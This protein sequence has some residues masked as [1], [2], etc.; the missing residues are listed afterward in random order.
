MSPLAIT[1]ARWVNSVQPT[2]L[3]RYLIYCE[4]HDADLRATHDND[5]PDLSAGNRC[6]RDRFVSGHSDFLAGARRHYF[7]RQARARIRR[8]NLAQ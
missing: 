1:L 4:P 6:Y 8:G 5:K 7:T 2:R 3:V